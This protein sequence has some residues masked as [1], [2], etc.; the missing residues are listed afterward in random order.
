MTVAVI[1]FVFLALTVFLSA[2]HIT[3]VR[4]QGWELSRS[5]IAWGVFFA[6]VQLL[7]GAYAAKGLVADDAVS[8]IVLNL[9]LT[10]AAATS[11]GRLQVVGRLL[12]FARPGGRFQH[13]LIVSILGIMLAGAFATLGLEIPSNHDLGWMY[14]LCLVLE[15]F[16]V[17]MPM[18]A[19][20]FLSQR[21]GAAPA[22]IAVALHIL[23]LAEHFVITFKSMPIQPGDLTALGT[24]MAVSSGYVYELNAFCLYGTM[25]AVIS[26]WL[27]ELAGTLRQ[28]RTDAALA[29]EMAS[30][31][32]KAQAVSAGDAAEAPVVD[33]A[34][35][36]TAKRSH[37][38]RTAR[39]RLIA[40]I[41]VGVAL[42][43]GL[44]AHV[45]LID[46]YNTLWVQVYSWRPLKSY[47]REG[48][49][50]CFVS[51][52]QAII[53]KKPADYDMDDAKKL[54]DV[55][56]SQ[57]DTGEGATEER[58][59]AK[60]QF[61]EEKPTVITIM[62]ETFSDLSIYENLHAN[63]QGPVYFKSLSDCLQRGVLYV[64]AYGGGTANTEFEY[65]TGNSMAYLGSG[66]YPYTIYDLSKTEN[67][68]S[69]FKKL[70]YDTTAMHPNH[71]TNWNR[72]N[73]YGQ[74]GFDQFLTI[75]DFQG[76]D[77]LRGMVT[78]R[79]TYEKILELLNTNSNPQFIFDVTMQNHS[80]YDT[81]ALPAD[82]RV[83]YTIDGVSDPEVNEYLSL[84][85]ESD[86]ALQYFINQLR[87]L[88]RKVIVVF[89]GD[90][91]PWFPDRFND[92]WFTGEDEATHAERLWQTDYI[93]WANYDVAGRDQSSTQ[94]DLSTN[95]LSAS[96]MNLIG[97][98]LTKYQ[99]AH[100]TLREAMPAINATGFEDASGRWFLSS[101]AADEM[102]GERVRQARQDLQVMQYYKLF[103]NGKDV[104]TKALQSA[105]NE[106][107]PNLAPGTTANP[108]A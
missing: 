6:L 91:Q 10:L 5:G 22:V 61:D 87:H 58:A 66:I 7:M 36:A 94:V 9:V 83:E 44:T 23:G 78:D 19:L 32:G 40:N 59:A 99:K 62:N 31:N 21:R 20:F 65:L 96:L 84:I 93:I 51:A 77:K 41:L 46:Y 79:A 60:Q 48:F 97:A 29:A 26:A 3:F 33:A 102:T 38:S 69:Q 68:A 108:G 103:G 98:P 67:L 86:S 43:A 82:K 101:A 89:F 39:G 12:A 14:P 104:F 55:Y 2:R 80:G 50:P 4:K 71:A 54:I 34:E 27:C 88:N 74:F 15:W 25:F 92:R 16:L 72:E 37:R 85:Q 53:P 57:Y 90:H 64:S 47:Y 13:P 1:C 49:L 100:E 42:L 107:N 52:T 106:T 45:T 35:P 30:V 105:A 24:A 18:M 75:N 17:T 8:A 95:Y 70:G 28:F 81:N 11:V 63:Y 73:I 76:A 56:A